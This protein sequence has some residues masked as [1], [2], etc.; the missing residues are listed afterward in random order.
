MTAR[1][2]CRQ[3]A[4]GAEASLSAAA[5]GWVAITADK[6]CVTPSGREQIAP[7]VHSRYNKR[8]GAADELSVNP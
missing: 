7:I 6:C 3:H 5:S 1:R 8:V 4:R 2:A